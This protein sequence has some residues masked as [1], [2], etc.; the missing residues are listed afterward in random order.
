MTRQHTAQEQDE[1]FESFRNA[2]LEFTNAA[3]LARIVSKSDPMQVGSVNLSGDGAESPEYLPAELTCGVDTE[4]IWAVSGGP[5]CYNYSGRG[6]Y[7]RDCPSKGKGK[8]HATLG[9][10]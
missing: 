2:V 10:F 8:S 7:A 1:T 3:G 5:T 9:G 6:H 4:N